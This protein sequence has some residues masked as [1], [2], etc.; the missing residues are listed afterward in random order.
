[1]SKEKK[2]TENMS[3]QWKIM[4]DEEGKN[5]FY[6]IEQKGIYI[7]DSN[8]PTFCRPG[9]PIPGSV[10]DL[11]FWKGGA[12]IGKNHFLGTVRGGKN[13]FPFAFAG[14]NRKYFLEER[15]DRKIL[16]HFEINPTQFRV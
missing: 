1:M 10:A 8:S 16:M 13:S 2:S 7:R 15:G 6:F 4:S 14:K 5:L 11:G 9:R 12:M 3:N